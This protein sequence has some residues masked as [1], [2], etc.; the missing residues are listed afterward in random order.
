ML[1]SHCSLGRLPNQSCR[2]AIACDGSSDGTIM[3]QRIVDEG[4]GSPN[5]ADDHGIIV[6]ILQ[7]YRF[8]DEEFNNEYLAKTLV[9]FGCDGAAVMLGNKQT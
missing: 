4:I 5:L 2:T 1:V 9:G 6:G 7:C 8:V 3:E